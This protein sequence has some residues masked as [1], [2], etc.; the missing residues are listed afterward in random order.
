M[1]YILLLILFLTGCRSAKV[2]EAKTLSIDSTYWRAS[3][4]Q[5]TH[6][7]IQEQLQ[8]TVIVEKMRPDTTGDLR[9]TEL[10]KYMV[11][12]ERDIGYNEEREDTVEYK[13]KSTNN[14]AGMKNTHK[15]RSDKPPNVDIVLVGIIAIIILYIIKK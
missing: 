10:T 7:D 3:L 11:N 4:A 6:A 15:G 12:A 9:L 1:K 5:L 14:T 8:M 2:E 13:E